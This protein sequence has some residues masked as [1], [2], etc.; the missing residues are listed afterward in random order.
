MFRTVCLLA[1]AFPVAGFL[2]RLFAAGEEQGMSD[3]TKEIRLVEKRGAFSWKV[4]DVMSNARVKSLVVVA[5]WWNDAEDDRVGDPEKAEKEEFVLE[6]RRGRE[7]HELPPVRR[8]LR[9]IATVPVPAEL[10]LDEEVRG[11]W[12]VRQKKGD[13][14]P[15]RVSIRMVYR[16]PWG[17]GLQVPDLTI[18]RIVFDDIETYPP[19]DGD[20]PE[21]R[22]FPKL[23]AEGRHHAKIHIRNAG[24]GDANEPTF[25]FW[26]TD[27]D[28]KGRKNLP[29]LQLEI[30]I[31][32]GESLRV[33]YTV[34]I[35]KLDPG[36]YRLHAVAD[37]SA[38]IRELDEDNNGYSKILRVPAP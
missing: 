30:Y 13:E 36:L 25:A 35:P 34:P 2:P 29:P 22:D 33:K 15:R 21:R 11:E 9:L 7:W 19:A 24:Y 8:D 20:L 10:F 28:G 17:K 12:I 4:R 18:E 26:I 37:P 31:R 23:S 3:I 14:P 1:V 16:V 27:L 5:D 6:I 32:E 38:R